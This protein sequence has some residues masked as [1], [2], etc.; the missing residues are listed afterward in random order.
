MSD[1]INEAF[2]L[3]ASTQRCVR[4]HVRAVQEEVARLREREAQLVESANQAWVDAEARVAEWEAR[5]DRMADLEQKVS[6]RVAEQD[7]V[8]RLS[9]KRYTDE[10]EKRQRLEEALREMTTAYEST[11]PD[12]ERLERLEKALG[13]ISRWP[14]A[15]VA[16][17]IALEA[18]AHEE[19]K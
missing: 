6:A 10:I 13:R 16:Q 1:S 2:D 15:G 9:R 12:Y 8:L 5:C 19:E 4:G 14:A 11:V 18:L 7:E 17:K 3:W